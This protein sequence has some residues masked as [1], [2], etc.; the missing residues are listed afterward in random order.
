MR[1]LLVE[2][3]LLSVAGTVLGLAAGW[4]TVVA[5]RAT[6]SPYL[7]LQ[8]H[9]EIDGAV[10]LFAISAAAAATVLFG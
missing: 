4:G 2:S 7:P 10:L 1:Q 9:I 3:A 6:E 8:S 5:L